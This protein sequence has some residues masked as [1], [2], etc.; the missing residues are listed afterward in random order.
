MDG[1]FVLISHNWSNTRFNFS[2][3]FVF[4][5]ISQNYFDINFGGFSNMF[6]LKAFVYHYW[7]ILPI[8][9][10]LVWVRGRPAW[11]L[12]VL[13]VIPAST[14]TEL[15]NLSYTSYLF[16]VSSFHPSFPSSFFVCCTNPLFPFLAFRM[17]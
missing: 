4:V 9:L 15:V 5:S 12:C 13:S 7:H 17:A 16:P 2:T 6:N 8:L 14:W 3:M 10:C 11:L 1:Y